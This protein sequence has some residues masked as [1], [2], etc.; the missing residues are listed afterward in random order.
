MAY[1]DTSILAARRVVHVDAC[2][3]DVSIPSCQMFIIEII[4]NLPVWVLSALESSV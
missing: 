2:M 4:K 3:S 1:R